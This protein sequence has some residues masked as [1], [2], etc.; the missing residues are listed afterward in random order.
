MFTNILLIKMPKAFKRIHIFI[1]IELLLQ[2]LYYFKSYEDGF[3]YKN[4][5]FIALL[6][7]TYKQQ[8]YMYKVIFC[9]EKKQLYS[10]E[11]L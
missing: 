3:H 11:K 1:S 5:L 6:T 4:L 10:C 7:S 2:E 9:L 8:E